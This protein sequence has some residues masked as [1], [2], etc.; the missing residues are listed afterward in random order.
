MK[1]ESILRKQGASG[2]E[3]EYRAALRQHTV[4]GGESGLRRAYELGRRALEEGRGLI[5]VASFHHHALLPLLARPVGDVQRRGLLEASAE[6]LVESLSP[7]EMAYRGFRDAIQALRRLNETL[8]AETKRIAVAVHDEAGQSLVAVHIALAELSREVPAA[9]RDRIQRIEGLLEQAE[10]Q[11]RRLSHELRPAVLDDL[12][13]IAAI[14]FLADGVSKRTGMPVR[15][16]AAFKGR[17]QSAV[18]TALYR[19][20]QEALTNTTKHAK[21]AHVTIQIRRAGKKVYCSIQD[22]GVGFDFSSVRSA[23]SRGLGLI[24]MQERLNAIGGSF[25]VRSAP[26]S[27]TR[28]AIQVPLD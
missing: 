20:V 9:Q 10:G 2:I 4:R 14:R 7:Y 17:L 25:S 19:V 8:E 5:E 15:I 16:Q 24:A 13:W 11:L 21:A 3:G 6:F 23:R 22:D 27:G 1:A 18:E 12:G 28:I 26:G